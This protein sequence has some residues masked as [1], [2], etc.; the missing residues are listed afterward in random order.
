M[1][2]KIPPQRPRRPGEPDPSG[3]VGG[4]DAGSTPIEKPPVGPGAG[5]TTT[6]PIE[7]TQTTNQAGSGTEAPTPPQDLGSYA[8]MTIDDEIENYVRNS[9]AGP[10]DTSVAEG[11]AQQ[12]QQDLLGQNLYN[13]RAASGAA[14][15]GASGMQMALEGDQRRR[16]SRDMTAQILGIRGDELDRANRQGAV[17]AGVDLAASQGAR[18]DAILKAQMDALAAALGGGGGGAPP[19]AAGGSGGG[20]NINSPG[21]G[22]GATD[23]PDATDNPNDTGEGHDQ[24]SAVSVAS[25]PAGSTL[26]ASDGGANYYTTPDGR[27]WRVP[28]RTIHDYG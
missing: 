21:A 14:G 17:G 7:Q 15:F 5:T 28:H 2:P 25:Q 11:L 22:I 12:N 1:A 16:A 27:W 10:Q 26:A 23:I 19:P 8:G 6:A 3:F 18:Q 24:G 20:I 13:Q 9:L 4:P